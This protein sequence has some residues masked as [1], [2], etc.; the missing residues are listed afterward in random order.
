[1]NSDRSIHFA[2]FA[3]D[4]A[5]GNVSIKGLFINGERLSKRIDSVLFLAIQKKIKASIVLRRQ[6]RTPC[7]IHAQTFASQRPPCRHGKR[8]EQQ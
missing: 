1:M 4:A 8:Q 7:Q 5:Q 6:L 2:A 3:Q